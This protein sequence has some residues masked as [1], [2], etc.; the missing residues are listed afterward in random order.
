MKNLLYS[1]RLWWEGKR[2]FVCP[3]AKEFGYVQ[4]EHGLWWRCSC[5]TSGSPGWTN[6]FNEVECMQRWNAFCLRRACWRQLKMKTKFVKKPR[7]SKA[8][9]RDKLRKRAELAGF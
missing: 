3:R 2:A 1:I 7:V 4:N 8:T 5:S 6:D 9:V